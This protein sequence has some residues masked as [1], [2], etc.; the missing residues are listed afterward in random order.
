LRNLAAI[1]LAA[2]MLVATSPAEAAKATPCNRCFA[3]LG[4]SGDLLR[5]RGV[6]YAART[7]VGRYRITFSR[8]INTCVA[9][10]TLDGQ[11]TGTPIGVVSLSRADNK[12]LNILTMSLNGNFASL[13]FNVFVNC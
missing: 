13:P 2:F 3:V 12:S 7:S 5:Y 8:P 11:N 4:S 10:A 6:L 9:S 1:G